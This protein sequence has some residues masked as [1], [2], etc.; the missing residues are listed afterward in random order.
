MFVCN[1]VIYMK[2]FQHFCHLKKQFNKSSLLTSWLNPA[3]NQPLSPDTVTDTSKW[4]FGTFFQIKHRLSSSSYIDLIGALEWIRI[5]K[6]MM[7]MWLPALDWWG[8][9]WISN[10]SMAGWR[11][12]RWWRNERYMNIQ[13]HAIIGNIFSPIN[14]RGELYWTMMINSRRSLLVSSWAWRYNRYQ[15]RSRRNS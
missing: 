13:W 14:E 1:W 3:Q 11:C 12:C 4:S 10:K 7:R 2:N 8:K 6:I 9:G 5:S 15:R